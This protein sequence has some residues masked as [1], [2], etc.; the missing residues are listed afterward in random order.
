MDAQ[1]QLIKIS[2]ILLAAF[3]LIVFVS[4]SQTDATQLDE[5]AEEVVAEESQPPSS[6]LLPTRLADFTAQEFKDAY[7]NISLPN[8]T[9]I[10]IAPEVTGNHDADKRISSIALSRGYSLRHVA[11]GLLNK[12]DDKPVQELLIKDWTDLKQRAKEEGVNIEFRSGYRSVED[13]R[14]L[15]LDRLRS[16][17]GIDSEIA[18][19]RQDD[20]VDSVLRTTAPPGYSRHHGGYT[21][22]V[23]DPG[24]AVFAESSAYMWISANNFEKAKLHGFIPSYPEGLTNQ[25]PNPEPWEF[26]WVSKGVTFE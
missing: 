8:I 24:F 14:E 18:A 25:G 17:G 21:I 2:L 3:A 5:R 16:A 10:I 1:K 19:G 11:S 6:E 12:I 13:Q 7:D 26:V 20:V 4:S 15:F 22:D 9:P 23:E